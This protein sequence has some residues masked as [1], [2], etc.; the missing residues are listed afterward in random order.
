MKYLVFD[1]E[2]TGDEP[3]WHEIVQ[4]GACLYDEDWNKL[5]T[6]LSNVYPDNEE[7]FSLPSA[8]IHGL[9]LEE[10]NEAPMLHEVIES[11]ETWILDTIRGANKWQAHQKPGLLKSVTLCGQSVHYDVNFLRYAYRDENLDWPYSHKT[12]DLYQFS[13]FLFK[14]LRSNGI[15]TPKSLSLGAVAYYFGFERESDIHNALEDSILTGKCL[16]K[17]LEY[18]DKLKLSDE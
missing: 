2:L 1:L 10:L 14:I 15:D 17:V 18:V 7:S 8:E 9:S 3:G 5:G 4:L 12:I 6:F 13:F 11:F 16:K